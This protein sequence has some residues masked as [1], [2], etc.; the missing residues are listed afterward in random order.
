MVWIALATWGSSAHAFGLGSTVGVQTRSDLGTLGPFPPTLDL[1]FDPVVLQLHLLQ[2]LDA[3]FDDALVFGANVYVDVGQAP[4]AGPWVA[5]A[6][7]GGSLFLLGEPDQL[8]IAGECRLG[9]Q[10]HE[11]AGFGVYLVPA[12]GL[13]TSNG[14]TELFAGGMLQASVWFDL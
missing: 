8:V 7:P 11:A 9:M 13:A 12:L 10:A 2:T 14:T 1:V 3:A 5:S 6:Q 4:I